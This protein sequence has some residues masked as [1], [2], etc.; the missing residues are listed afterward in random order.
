MPNLK[1]IKNS[2]ISTKSTQKIT[3]AMKMISTARLNKAKNTLINH[4]EYHNSIQNFINALLPLVNKENLETSSP[5]VESLYNN[6]Q[7]KTLVILLSTDKGLCGALNTMLFKEFQKNITPDDII[8][9]CGKKAFEFAKNK[10]TTINTKQ[11]LTAK[12]QNH[13]E[14]INEVYGIIKS[15]NIGNIKIISPEFISAISQQPKASM[16]ISKKPTNV[17]QKTDYIIEGCPLKTLENIMYKLVESFVSVSLSELLCSEHGARM[18][19]MDNATTN[20]TK[21][22][23]HLTKIYNKTRQANITKEILEIVA[24]NISK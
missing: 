6:T 15:H 8:L 9:T 16:L 11:L 17:Y 19:A 21:K 23:S 5:L 20:A 24:G 10:F 2:I 14:I 18:V 3:K 7:S 4:R 1:D 22:I 12:L 13:K